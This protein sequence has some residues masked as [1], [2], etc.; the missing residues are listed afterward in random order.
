MLDRRAF[1]VG[2]V[3]GAIALA[4]DGCSRKAWPQSMAVDVPAG[5][6]R[7]RVVESTLT[8]DGKTGLAYRIQQDDGTLGYTGAKGQ[9]FQVALENATPR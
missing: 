9:R 3:S 2:A 4:I 5:F 1:T 6:T 8:V 7:L